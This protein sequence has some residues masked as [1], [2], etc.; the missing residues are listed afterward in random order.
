MRTL[1]RW[2]GSAGIAASRCGTWW[3]STRIRLCLYSA[4]S[5]TGSSAWAKA[6]PRNSCPSN[7]QR[8]FKARPLPT[9]FDENGGGGGGVSIAR[10]ERSVLLCASFRPQQLANIRDG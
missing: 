5:A 9:L 8:E 3:P 2:G 6:N 4:A 7:Y 10:A 1:R